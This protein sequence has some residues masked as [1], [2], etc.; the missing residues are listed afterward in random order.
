MT[1]YAEFH[2]RSLEDRDAF[3]GEQAR[4]VDW[5]TQPQQVCDYTNPPFAKWF[6]GGT[7]N[8]CHNAVD[9]HLKDRAD[10]AALI[11]VSTETNQEKVYSFRELHAEVQRMAAVLKDLGVKKSDRVLI[12]M[13]MIADAA[14]AMLACAR[15]G[16]IHSV[17]FGGFASGSLASRIEDAS[18]KVI[19]SADAGSRGGKAVAYKP[20]LDEAI[21]LSSHKPEAVLLV[22]RGLVPM[23][24]VAGRDHLWAALRQK[25][26]STVVPCEWVDATHPSYTLYTSGT[27]GKPKGVQRDTGGYA[28]ALAASMKHIYCGNAGETYFSTS[29]IG[30]VVGHSYIIYG[31]LIAGMAT[32]MYEGLPTRPDGGIWW[33]LVEKYKVTVMFSAP[34]AIRVLKKQDPA[35]LKKYDL[36]S[37]RALFLA[38]EPLDQPTA[39]WISEGLGR[40]IVDN[41]WQTETGW[42]I[43]SICKGVDDSPTKFGSPGKAVYGYNVKLLDENTGEELKGANQKGVVAIEG[44]LPP[45]CLQTVWGDDARFVSTYWTTIPGRMVYSTFDWGIRDADGYYFIL[46]RTDDVIN[47][48]GHRL[49]T[50]EIEES[51]SA[52]PNIAEVAVVGV[53]DQLK[54]QVAMAFAVVKD[55]TLVADEAGRLKLEG[56]IMKLVDG[57]LGAVARPARVRFVTVLPKTRSGKLLRRAVQAV[58]EGRDPGDLTTMEDPAALQQIKDLVTE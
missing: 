41:Y 42:P 52:H 10:Q 32:I 27:T 34:T 6:V 12:Y 17:V 2:R 28:V 5:Q 53:A 47:V 49:G 24:L 19:I 40:P 31:P 36:S 51:I 22:D 33:S 20:L 38:G 14:F 55:M 30:W 56:E 54:G 18:P 8:L 45:G 50:R 25:H 4:L 21:R 44:P 57:D 11:F 48:A 1:N 29:D 15:I 39:Q 37:L 7:T 35:L 46:G 43:L 9:R 26:M 58:C 13:P 3:W 23:N 16:A